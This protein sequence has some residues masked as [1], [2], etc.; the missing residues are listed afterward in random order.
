M[1]NMLQARL[2]LPASTWWGRRVML[3]KRF[4]SHDEDKAECRNMST[5]VAIMKAA[6]Q[7]AVLR[8]SGL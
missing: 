5:L 2:I 4:A 1:R 6:N 8:A 7:C 3:D